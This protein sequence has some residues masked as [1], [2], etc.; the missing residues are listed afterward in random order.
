MKTAERGAAPLALPGRMIVAASAVGAVVLMIAIR[1][2]GGGP[3][4]RVRH[5]VL[6]ITGVEAMMM[7]LV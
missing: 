7:G 6:E 4:T 3:E 2:H 5:P 1:A